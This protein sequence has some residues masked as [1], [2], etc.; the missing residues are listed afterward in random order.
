MASTRRKRNGA[1]GSGNRR[2]PPP[3]ATGCTIRHPTEVA[4]RTSDEAIDR[5]LHLKDQLAHAAS[6]A[7]TLA[8]ARWHRRAPHASRACGESGAGM[9]TNPALHSVTEQRSRAAATLPPR[10]SLPSWGHSRSHMRAA[11]R[12]RNARAAHLSATG[13]WRG[14]FV[15]FHST[16][17]SSPRRSPRRS[18]DAHVHARGVL[19]HRRLNRA[20]RS[21]ALWPR[22]T[23]AIGSERV[24]ST[25]G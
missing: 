24:L 13:R 14:T 1:L 21:L 25:Q 5:A 23:A 3:S 19:L 2:R 20:T 7:S 6:I 22:T 17:S 16:P 10:A 8:T 15:A 4:I 9:K 12:P 11:W 18:T